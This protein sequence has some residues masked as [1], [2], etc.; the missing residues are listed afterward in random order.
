MIVFEAQFVQT[1]WRP[2]IPKNS[3]NYP[4]LYANPS[5]WMTSDTFYRWFEEW[6]TNTRTYKDDEIEKRLFIYD[7]HLSHVWY[8]TLELARTQNVTIIK[9]PPHTTDL[10]QPLDVSVFKALKGYWADILFKRI[11]STRARLS[12]AEFST[13]LCDPE[14]WKKAF[15][16]TNVK[17]GFR[18]CGIHPVDRTKYPTNRFSVTL[19]NQYGKWVEQGKPKLSAEELDKMIDETREKEMESVY[20]EEPTAST[21]SSN[22]NQQPITIDGKNG[23]VVMYF[24][25]DE[26]PTAIERI[27]SSLQIP[28]PSTSSPVNFKEVALKKLDE[29]QSRKPTNGKEPAKRKRVNPLANI[30]TSD[31][32]F[33]EVLDEIK[34]KEEE[35][36]AKKARKEAKQLKAKKGKATVTKKKESIKDLINMNDIPEFS[37]DDDDVLDTDSD[38]EYDFLRD[39]EKKEKSIFPPKNDADA[40]EYLCTVWDELNPPSAESDIVGKYVGVMYYDAKQRPHLFVGK[41]INRFLHDENGPAKQLK[42]HVMFKRAATSTSTLLEEV[43]DHFTKDITDYPVYDVICGP[44]AATVLRG[45]K[46]NVPEYPLAYETFNVVK[47]LDRK[48]EYERM[49]PVLT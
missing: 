21:S 31:E 6:E 30:V 45:T 2:T 28:S 38:G 15:S 26:N 33:Q 39:E 13:N 42:I 37:S 11:R 12:K 29:L 44:L 8:G 17:N 32:S 20:E 25:P 47:G 24:V 43:P 35:E 1:T 3:K 46:W 36:R 48:A 18:T 49:Y 40:I 27:D 41:I 14:V 19:K 34:Q 16:E 9:L 7:G 4:W 22:D 10:L 5:G 23:K